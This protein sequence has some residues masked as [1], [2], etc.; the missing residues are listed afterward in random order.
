MEIL[1]PTQERLKSMYSVITNN[2]ISHLSDYFSGHKDI[3]TRSIYLELRGIN[4][5][6]E[7]TA[8]LS[9]KWRVGLEKI[10]LTSDKVAII[11]DLPQF[12]ENLTFYTVENEWNDYGE[13]LIKNSDGSNT[14]FISP[15]ELITD[16]EVDKIRLLVQNKLEKDFIA[17]KLSIL[18]NEKRRLSNE[19]N[20][21]LKQ[22]LLGVFSRLN[23]RGIV[24]DE[25][26]D[27]IDHLFHEFLV[28]DILRANT[29][30]QEAPKVG[31][32]VWG[33]YSSLTFGHYYHPFKVTKIDEHRIYEVGD[34]EGYIKS[35]LTFYPFSFYLEVMKIALGIEKG[36]KIQLLSGLIEKLKTNPK[37]TRSFLN[38]A[39]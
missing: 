6:E 30:K 34:N 21:S 27:N 16:L 5:R 3:L 35:K 14:F 28:A 37:L 26:L 23:K 13:V 22:L 1:L 12:H 19:T 39:S 9:L 20:K 8:F 18:E 2:V 24:V 7:L 32:I 25:T 29:S 15:S 17:S 11:S 33:Y 36:L 4:T 38:I 31:D 10:P